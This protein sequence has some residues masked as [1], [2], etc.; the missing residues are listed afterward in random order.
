MPNNKLRSMPLLFDS[1]SQKK[2]IA[3]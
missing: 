1:F 3:L 2:K